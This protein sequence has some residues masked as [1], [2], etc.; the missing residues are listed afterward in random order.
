MGQLK[1]LGSEKLPVNEKIQRIMEIARYKDAPK[2]APQS[3]T[4]STHLIKESNNGIYGIV[5]EKD[6]YYVKFGLNESTLDY[7][8]GMRMKNKN[9]FNSYAEALK[10]LELIARPL[11]EQDKK[12]MLN[13]QKPSV[14]EDPAS[15]PSVDDAPAVDDATPDAETAPDAAVAPDAGGDEAGADMGAL[16]TDAGETPQHLKVIQKITGK[17][18]QKLRLY[19]DELKSNDYKYVIN[20]VLSA[21]D[22]SKMDDEDKESIAARFEDDSDYDTTDNLDSVDDTDMGMDADSEAPTTP[23]AG[24]E[25]DMDDDAAPAPAG[26][27]EDLGEDFDDIYEN[28]RRLERMLK[29]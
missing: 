10:R 6:G 25:A 16:Q 21:I 28:F 27:D 13:T 24:E 5:R 4:S 15:E 12:Y 23:D 1:P 8:G 22:L 14:D 9:R 3:A 26:E 11:T 7:I 18:G 29:G 20:S 2:A 17:L 19:A